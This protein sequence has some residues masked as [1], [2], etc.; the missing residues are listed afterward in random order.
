MNLEC[1]E[2][3]IRDQWMLV[4][5]ARPKQLNVIDEASL[6]ELEQ[7]LHFVEAENIKSVVITGQGRAFAA[8]ADVSAMAK[9]DQEKAR[10]FS[11]FGNR[12]FQLIEDHP[13]V[14]LAAINGFALGGGLELAL[15][16]DIRFASSKASFGQPEINLGIIPGFGGTQRL[17]RVIGLSRAKEWILTG[18]RFTAEQALEVGLVTRVYEQEEL[19]D[20]A[21]SFAGEIAKKSA[22]ILALAK[23]A[24]A[25]SNLGVTCEMGKKEAELFGKCFTTEDGPEGIKAFLE[26]RSAQFKDQ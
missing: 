6:T 3:T 2:I 11:E 23:E 16:C 18:E 22:P 21:E 5:M 4:E 12:V 13:A 17:P 9:M 20:A 26:K 19:K 10:R 15:A 7:I 24:I 1:F 14:F 25:A 8:G